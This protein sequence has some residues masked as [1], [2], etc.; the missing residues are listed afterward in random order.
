MGK[1][2]SRRLRHQARFLAELA[3]TS[4]DCFEA[5]W[6]TRLQDWVRSARAQA[7]RLVRRDGRAERPLAEWGR[8]ILRL[9]EACG[10]QAVERVGEET[11]EVLANE[12]GKAVAYAAD[13][14][15]WRLHSAES[16]RRLGN[17]PPLPRE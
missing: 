7:N 11:R 1:A 15:L 3:R 5:E 4:L 2:R 17:A 14:R 16:A 12:F 9:L 8:D 10:R 13:P 6:A